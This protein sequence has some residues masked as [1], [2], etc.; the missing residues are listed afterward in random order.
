MMKT[1]IT[2]IAAKLIALLLTTVVMISAIADFTALMYT[3]GGVE[4]RQTN[5]SGQAERTG[6]TNRNNAHDRRIG[7]IRGESPNTSGNAPVS[8][9]QFTN[10]LTGLPT[11]TDISRNRPVAISVSNQ[12]AAL[13]TN[14]TNGISQA[15]IVYEML[16][17]HGIT[18]LV[19]VYQ[20]FSNAGVVGSIRSARHYTVEIA[21]AYDALFIHAG[22]SPLGYEEIEKRGITNFDEVTGRRGQIFSR[23]INRVPGQTVDNYHSVTTSGASFTRGLRTYEGIRTT[24]NN[25]FR[26][27]LKFTDNPIQ[28]G[29]RAAEVAIRFSSFKDSIFV[30]DE[31][32]KVYHMAQFG[33][34]FTDANNG[35]PVAFT[36]LL[37]LEMPIKDLTGNGEGAGRHDMS[38]TGSGRGYFISAGRSVRINWQRA[39]K[40]SPFIYTLENGNE[41]ELG[42]GKTYIGI[43]PVGAGIN[44]D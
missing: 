11:V 28:S 37:I 18:R 25:N 33:S 36:N 26:Q 5:Q 9:H 8:P 12:R 41:I 32:Q 35:A 4:G 14:A 2:R 27:T 34:Y 38:T 30:Y 15:D 24:H 31:T 6:N 1:R 7:L 10:P 16:V 44:I 40:S 17:E 20:D 39:D 29:N 19:A 22:G 21:E 23:D 13:P 3:V 43:V 42:R